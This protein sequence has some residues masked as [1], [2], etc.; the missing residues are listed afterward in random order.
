[1]DDGSRSRSTVYLNTQQFNEASH[2]ALA[3][4]LL[5]QFGIAST[6]NRDKIY[7]RLRVA[8][9]SMTQFMDLVEPHVLPMFR[10]TLPSRLAGR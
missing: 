8:V 4:A 1:M 2:L 7:K 3:D 6:L 9:G 10:Y 5:N